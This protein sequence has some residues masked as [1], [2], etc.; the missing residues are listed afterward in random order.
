MVK[1]VKLPGIQG[2]PTVVSTQ[3]QR[4]LIIRSLARDC[5]GAG[6]IPED[7]RQWQDG[8]LRAKALGTIAALAVTGRIQART[9]IGPAI[10]SPSVPDTVISVSL[11]SANASERPLHRYLEHC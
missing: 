2:S 1:W 4:V 7:S 10:R 8:P 5:Q 9:P 11:R 3:L 6:K